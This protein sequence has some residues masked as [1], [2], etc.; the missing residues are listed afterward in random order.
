MDNKEI[1]TVSKSLLKNLE[2]EISITKQTIC[3]YVKQDTPQKMDRQI[4]LE[5]GSYGDTL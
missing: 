4:Q 1:V 5:S 3:E 2:R